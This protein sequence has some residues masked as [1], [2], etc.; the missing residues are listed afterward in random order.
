ELPPWQEVKHEINLIDETKQYS[1]FMPKCSKSFQ[2]QLQD[3]ID[4]Y[5]QN[6]ALHELEML[7]ILEALLKWEDKLLGY[8]IHVITDYCQVPLT[9][10]AQL[11][12]ASPY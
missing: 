2:Q 3:K 1:Y 5:V 7:V 10:G 12:W 11:H 4:C 8:E 6:Y 9:M